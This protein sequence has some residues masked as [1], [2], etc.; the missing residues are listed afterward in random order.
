[1]LKKESLT[2]EKKGFEI[3]S[4]NYYTDKHLDKVCEICEIETNYDDEQDASE[5]L[6][7]AIKNRARVTGPKT[8]DYLME[9]VTLIEKKLSEHI[10]EKG[11][12]METLL[13]LFLV[14]CLC[15]Y[16]GTSF[17]LIQVKLADF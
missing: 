3:Y 9:K 11:C 15:L 12:N 5:Y 2:L 6:V 16:L 7:Q 14:I 1:M 10:D 8:E 17:G 13:E 4:S